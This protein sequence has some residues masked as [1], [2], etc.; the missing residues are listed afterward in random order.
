M[1]RRR[2]TDHRE[3]DR[4]GRGAAA[5]WA[6]FDQDGRLVF[7]KEGRL[8]AL[9]DPRSVDIDKAKLLIDL[10]KREPSRVI[11]PPSARKW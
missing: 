4:Q 9:E 5:A 3:T 6:D 11:A 10:N 8:F 7:A 1:T 2:C